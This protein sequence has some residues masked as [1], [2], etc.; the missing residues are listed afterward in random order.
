LS[1]SLLLVAVSLVAADSC[2]YGYQ[3]YTYN[4]TDLRNDTS[5]YVVSDGVHVY[6][7]NFCGALV[8]PTHVSACDVSTNDTQVCQMWDNMTVGVSCGSTAH[9]AATRELFD[10]YPALSLRVTGGTMRFGVSAQSVVHLICNGTN[11]DAAP[12][13]LREVVAFFE[14]HFVWQRQEVCAGPAPTTTTTAPTT[15]TVTTTTATTTTAST[16]SN[17]STVAPA[18]TTANA[19]STAS[20]T[21]GN[22]TAMTTESGTSASMTKQANPPSPATMDIRLIIVLAVLG[23][24][25]L[26]AVVVLICAY[27]ARRRKRLSGYSALLQNPE[28]FA[29]I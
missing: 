28:K 12:S 25:I 29:R 4:M 23:G 11:H 27:M 21:A 6:R 7:L 14:Y 15:T 5:D 19:T 10:V 22:N 2:L 8:Q 20:T 3:N 26:V 16:T 1:A 24:L 17:A 13:F 18:T 9:V